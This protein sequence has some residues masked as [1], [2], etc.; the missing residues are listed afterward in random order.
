MWRRLIGLW[1]GASLLWITYGVVGAVWR[2]T[3]IKRYVTDDAL[4]PLL[5]RTALDILAPVV[6]A[7][8]FL[9]GLLAAVTAIVRVAARVSRGGHRFA[10]RSRVRPR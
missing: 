7:G 10:R 8:A 5:A 3:E 2:W 1:L 6:V 9:L 4:A